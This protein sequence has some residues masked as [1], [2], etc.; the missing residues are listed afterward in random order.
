MKH[1]LS[2]LFLAASVSAAPI[3]ALNVRV[4]YVET[5][6]DACFAAYVYA[7]TVQGSGAGHV[8]TD[9]MEPVMPA[10]RTVYVVEPGLPEVGQPVLFKHNGQ[11]YLHML[12]KRG[13]GRFVTTG[14]NVAK[15]DAGYR[16]ERDIA[17]VVRHVWVATTNN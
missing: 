5:Y 3:P 17:G 9:S 2:L 16:I 14:T 7:R 4:H 15:E 12:K 10:K 1:F 11:T 8:A 13:M 6:A